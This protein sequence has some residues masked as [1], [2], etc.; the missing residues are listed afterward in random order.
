MA[1]PTPKTWVAAEFV[2]AAEFNVELRDTFNFLLAPPR[3]YAFKTSDGALANASWGALNF[4][5]ELYDSNAAHDNSTNNTRLV[6]PESGLYTIIAHTMFE[7]SSAGLR[8]I[9]VRKNANAVQTG[10]TDL[11]MVVQAGNGTTEARLIVAVDAQLNAG[12]YVESF[13]WQNSGA[14][15]NVIGG[16]ANCFLSFRWASK[17]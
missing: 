10:G 15:L 9:D 13:A 4:N 11:S 5:G 16:A 3:C 8:L 14:P 17:L 1:V 2:D 6:A 12:D 7:T